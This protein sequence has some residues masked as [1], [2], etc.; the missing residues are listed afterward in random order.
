M[1]LIDLKILDIIIKDSDTPLKEIG[2]I[3]GINSP[4][5]VSKRIK[6]LKEE[7]VIKKFVPIIDYSKFGLNFIAVTF[8]RAKYGKSYTDKL[9]LKLK[10]VSGLI[11]LLEILGEID[12]VMITLNKDQESYKENMRYMMSL[13]EVER[14]DT[15]VV[16]DNFMLCDFGN[17]NLFD[18]LTEKKI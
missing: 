15:R 12:F 8:I 10:N 13:D 7:N 9:S 1:D 16:V 11:T 5:A 14:T 4:S 18:S 17:I 6:K 3:C 2:R